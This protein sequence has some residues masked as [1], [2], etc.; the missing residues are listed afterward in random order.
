[1]KKRYEILVAVFIF[2]QLIQLWSGPSI[3]W[4]WNRHNVL[5]E[6]I[7]N[8]VEWLEKFDK[9]RVTPYRYED[10]SLNPK[11]ETLYE[12]PDP[13]Y[14]FLAS[15]RFVYIDIN[16]TIKYGFRG[17]PLNG[18][19]SAKDILVDYS[20]EPDWGMDQN[21]ELGFSQKLMG[22]SQGYRHMYYRGGSL[23]LPNIILPQGEAPNRVKHFYE[24]AKMAFSDGDMYWG[25]RFLARALHYIQDL[26]QPYHTTQ[27]SLSFIDLP[28]LIEGTIQ[29]TKNYHFAFE[30]YVAQIAVLE[31][32][33]L[34]RP[35]YLSALREG[36][37]KPISNPKQ[38]AIDTA[39]KGNLSAGKLLKANIHFFGNKY[40]S[41]NRIELNE[42]DFEELIKKE[43]GSEFNRFTKEALRQVAQAT[44]SF[45]EFVRNDI[46]ELASQK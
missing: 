8:D 10:K 33:G 45:L 21:L 22:G 26:A 43:P 18:V 44:K 28:S 30:S 46:A 31:N 16:T 1:M 37:A 27:T 20:D 12:N 11:F 5:T 39:T 40:K 23:H 19:T 15:S 3:S 17:E 32:A 42:T 41:A 9:I 38:L 36:K 24:L 2:S 29:T 35:D 4:A 14:A 34:K 25:F 13:R 6:V 7:L